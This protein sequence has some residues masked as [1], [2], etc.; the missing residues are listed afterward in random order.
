MR[1]EKDI[2]LNGNTYK[3]KQLSPFVAMEV[4]LTL[5]KLFG[6]DLFLLFKDEANFLEAI[7]GLEIAD[8]LTL[9]RKL[10]QGSSCVTDDKSRPINAD[11]A[12]EGD[13]IGMYELLVFVLRVNF[14]DFFLE[15]RS[16]VP[17]IVESFNEMMAS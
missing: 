1:V 4:Q 6:G 12:F 15:L 3:V 9:A 14:E 13:L 16:K 10:I 7:R 8:M 2:E 5:I 11:V 17:A